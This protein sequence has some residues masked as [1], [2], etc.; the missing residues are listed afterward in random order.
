MRQLLQRAYLLAAVLCIWSAPLGAQVFPTLPSNTVI[1]R[2]GAGVA[3]PPQAIPFAV[4]QPQILGAGTDTNV[5]NT[6]I[7]NYTI[8]QSD[9]GKT[10]QA[11]TGSTGSF[12]LTLPT[13]T[14]FLPT[15]S[16]LIKNG[17]TTANKTLSG[18]P[19]DAGTLLVPNETIGV[20]IL[21]GAW[22]VFYNPI[23]A[24]TWTPTI[25]AVTPGDLTIV[26]SFQSG[27]WFR[28][29][30]FVYAQCD[31]VTSTFTHTTAS[32]Q[33]SVNSL[34]YNANDD[35]AGPLDFQGINKTGGYTAIHAVTAASST[36]VFF[37]TNGMNLAI[38]ETNIT[39]MPSAGTV[40]LRFSIWYQTNDP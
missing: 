22:V 25:A 27:R 32:G 33:M 36:G 5:L 17:D 19:T 13:V 28:I 6:Q 31:V 34:P 12:T 30:N 7:A 3:G 39:D 16:V 11:G 29:G 18:F 20:K 10:I 23:R 21:N 4:L 1:G 26:Y 2:L 24:G 38:A 37:E 14:G 40:V 9:C 15:R 8:A 35:Y